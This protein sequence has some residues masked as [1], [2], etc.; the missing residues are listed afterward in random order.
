MDLGE[1]GPHE[2]QAKDGPMS[3]LLFLNLCISLPGVSVVLFPLFSYLLS[4]FSPSPSVLLPSSPF[5]G[6]APTS[7]GLGEWR[8]WPC[9]A[10]R[11]RSRW[12]CGRGEAAPPRGAR[13]LRARSPPAAGGAGRGRGRRAAGELSARAGAA[14]GRQRRERR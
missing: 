3:S 4:L 9:R 7:L 2:T 6:A 10:R 11:E 1:R 12:G 8:T 5:L 14:E 13:I